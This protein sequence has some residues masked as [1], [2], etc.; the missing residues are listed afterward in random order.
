MA[1]LWPGV[2]GEVAV[3]CCPGCGCSRAASEHVQVL[4]ALVLDFF[5]FIA[6]LQCCR[7][8]TLSSA[9][10]NRRVECNVARDVQHNNN[11]QQ[12]IPLFFRL[13]SYFYFFLVFWSLSHF[14]CADR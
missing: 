8:G 7:A 5:L 3:I 10:C 4:S 1:M 12:R 6:L 9:F 11:Q 14:V 2:V 13:A